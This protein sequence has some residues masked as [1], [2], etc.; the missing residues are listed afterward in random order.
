MAWLAATFHDQLSA[1]T[2]PRSSK[3]RGTQKKQRPSNF[4][5]A[6]IWA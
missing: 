6:S 2:E 4:L 3:N 1:G 5:R